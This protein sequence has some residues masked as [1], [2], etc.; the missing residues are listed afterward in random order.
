MADTAPALPVAEGDADVATGESRDSSI[1]TATASPH[2]PT[3]EAIAPDVSDADAA[4]ANPEARSQPPACIV[5]GM[6]G[7]GK[8]SLMQRIAAH[9]S[10]QN[11]PAYHINLDPAVTKVPFGANIDICDTVNYREVMKQYGLCLLY[12]SDAADE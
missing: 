10:M 4:A 12:T 9:L 3:A 6:A 8:T 7:S 1:A 11:T 2:T 5:L